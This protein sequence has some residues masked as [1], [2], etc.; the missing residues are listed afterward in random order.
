M[1]RYA[2]G[3]EQAFEEL[4]RRY[5]SRAYAFFT[6]RTRSP[7]RARDLYQELFLR[8]HRGRNSYD[9]TRPFKPWFFQIARRVLF[10]ERE[11]THW[12]QDCALEE[13][14]ARAEL[15][16]SD[17][18]LADRERLEGVMADLSPL[19]VHLIVASKLNGVGYRELAHELDKSVDAVKKIASRAMQR[20]RGASRPRLIIQRFGAR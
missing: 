4:F 9:A 13:D 15:P 20:I 12:L 8:I 17:E 14:E 11:R 7:E 2:S 3:D 6:T 19:E 10:D 1:G 16:G 5:E 18:R